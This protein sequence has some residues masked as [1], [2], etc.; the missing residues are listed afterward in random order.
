MCDVCV[1]CVWCGTVDIYIIMHIN[2]DLHTT[3]IHIPIYVHK[4]TH[5]YNPMHTT[6]NLIY[7][8]AY[9]DIHIH[10]H[11]HKLHTVHWFVSRTIPRIT[12]TSVLAAP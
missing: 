1:V 5:T 12:N 3:P 11:T 8:Y 4:H 9:I 6:Y 7:T 2:P 10:T